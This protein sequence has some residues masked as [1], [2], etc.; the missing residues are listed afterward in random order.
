MNPYPQLGWREVTGFEYVSDL[1]LC[2]RQQALKNRKGKDADYELGEPYEV[3][4]W[5]DGL[6]YHIVAPAGMLTDL[7]SVPRL[8][9]SL[10][11]IGRIGPHLEASIIHDW[12]YTA[13]QTLGL[14]PLQHMRLFADE[15]LLAGM[16]TAKISW[17]RR[18][19]I[20]T[21]VRAF[22]NRAFCT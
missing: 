8:A 21:A 7:S 3:V 2:R 17:H 14:I 15:V 10:T 12:L 16:K 18:Q 20:Y 9:W 19:M 6:P 11:G 4:V 13:W 5:I 22:G 1:H